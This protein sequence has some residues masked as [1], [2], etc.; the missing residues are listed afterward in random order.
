M[1][2]GVSYKFNNLDIQR[3]PS[4]N[5]KELAKKYLAR[6]LANEILKNISIDMHAD[7][8]GIEYRCVLEIVKN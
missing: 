4:D 5:R 8:D 6:S 2:I 3:I 1:K 7:N